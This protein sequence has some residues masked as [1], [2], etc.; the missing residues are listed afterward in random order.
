VLRVLYV[1]HVSGISGAEKSLLRLLEALDRSQVHP[2]LALPDVSG[3]LANAAAELDVTVLA[4]P[5]CRFSRK[6][7]PALWA[8]QLWQL[9]QAGLQ[10][11]DLRERWSIDLIHFNS[12]QAALA[13]RWLPPPPPLVLSARDLYF[14]PLAMRYATSQAALTVAISRAV[15]EEVLRV[16]PGAAG[17]L[18]VVPSGLVREDV[19]VVHTREEVRA[20]L[21]IP[22]SAPLIGAVAQIVPWKRLDAFLR[23]GVRL[24]A[25]LPKARLLMVGGD[26]FGDEAAHLH[27]LEALVSTLGLSE[28]VIWTGQ[29]NDVPDLI[30]SLDVLIHPARREPLGRVILEAMAVGTPVVA[31]DEAGAAEIIEDGVNGLLVPADE[32][33]NLASAALQVIRDPLLADTL[34]QGGFERVRRFLARDTAAAT[35]ELYRQ[36]MRTQPRL[37]LPGP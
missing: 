15:A 8:R 29:R 26:P 6:L 35:L 10:L 5:L 36:V 3:P 13:A 33:A 7:A 24:V 25:E 27:E 4:V 28:R 2:F 22:A 12:L 21:A 32:G 1:N 37:E 30:A 19:R 23:A 14:P 17:K 34:R 11:T 16:A 18:A 20:E 9:R 31:V